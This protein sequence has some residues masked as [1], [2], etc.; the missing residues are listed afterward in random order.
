MKNTTVGFM[1]YNAIGRA[2]TIS[3]GTYETPERRAIVL[4]GS[5]K[6]TWAVCKADG[7]EKIAPPG[8]DRDQSRYVNFVSNEIDRLWTDLSR[9]IDELD[10]IVIY[11]G[12]KGSERA[13]ELAASLS[14]EKVTL[15]MCDCELGR[16]LYLVSQTGKLKE[17]RRILCE[18]GGNETFHRM[19]RCYLETGTVIPEEVAQLLAI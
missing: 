3:N 19:F 4:Q 1:T 13:L 7:G 14:P 9:A 10:H 17:A 16:K 11:V 18:C 5:P 12:A 6:D 8:Y 15:V 2:G